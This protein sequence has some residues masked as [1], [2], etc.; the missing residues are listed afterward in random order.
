MTRER[1]RNEKGG[2][3]RW[4][5]RVVCDEVSFEEFFMGRL[6]QILCRRRLRPKLG[7]A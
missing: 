3:R 1:L 7:G 6:R 2:N 4:T 5:I